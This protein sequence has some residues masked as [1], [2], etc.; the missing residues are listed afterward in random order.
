MFKNI[1]EHVQGLEF[2]P[3]STMLIC[4][5]LFVGI[6]VYA[7]TADKNF[8]KYMSKLPLEKDD[9]SQLINGENHG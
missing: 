9:N 1:F 5:A 2:L 8:I 6:V 3:I 7:V 4:F